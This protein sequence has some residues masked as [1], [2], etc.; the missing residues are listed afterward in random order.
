MYEDMQEECQLV[1]NGIY[2]GG[3]GG[4]V[5]DHVKA[6]QFAPG[7]KDWRF[8]L[9][10]GSDDNAGLEWTGYGTLYFWIR[11]EDLRHRDFHNV[12]ALFQCT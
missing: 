12:W 3:G 10:V 1:S 8:L 9:E 11:E 7:I 4:P 2:F 6:A 5:F